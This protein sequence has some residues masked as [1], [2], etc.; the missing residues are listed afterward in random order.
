MARWAGNYPRGLVKTAVVAHSTRQTGLEE[1]CLTVLRCP[2]E[3]YVDRGHD[4]TVDQRP[5]EGEDPRR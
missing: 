3:T 5:V 1:Y 4:E 2:A